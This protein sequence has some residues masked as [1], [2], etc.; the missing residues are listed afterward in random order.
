MRGE[1]VLFLQVRPGVSYK[2]VHQ[3]PIAQ[4]QEGDY[5]YY[6]HIKN[7]QP[8]LIF[9]RTYTLFVCVEPK[10]LGQNGRVTFATKYAMSGNPLPDVT[11]P[12]RGSTF[13]YLRQELQRL[14]TYDHLCS[15]QTKLVF[16]PTV[17]GNSKL[18]SVFKKELK[19]LDR[20]EMQERQ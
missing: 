4:T 1:P 15:E 14:M 20:P 7:T 12:V 16:V 6:I 5:S 9:R 10:A 17:S 11:L 8:P 18:S 3:F 13:A 2:Y 19:E